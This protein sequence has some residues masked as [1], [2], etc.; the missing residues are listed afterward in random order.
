M[1]A[2]QDRFSGIP[3][4][5]LDDPE[6]VSLLIPTLR[7]DVALVE[8]YQYRED[9]PLS[10]PIA[11]YGGTSDSHATEDDLLAWGCETTRGLWARMFAGFG[12]AEETSRSAPTD[13]EKPRSRPR[14]TNAPAT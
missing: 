12:T 11:A 14:T 5:V 6:L 2:V 9:G 1:V 10:C 7:A 4:A 3:R 8:Q 13:G